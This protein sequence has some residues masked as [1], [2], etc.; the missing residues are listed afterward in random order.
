MKAYVVT[1]VHILANSGS[2]MQSQEEEHW[3]R[4]SEDIFIHSDINNC[5]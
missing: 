5:A 4:T 2:S 1:G 3:V